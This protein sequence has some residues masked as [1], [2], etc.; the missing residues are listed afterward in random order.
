MRSEKII[1]A[2]GGI[3]GI[4][5]AIELLKAGFEVEL[6]ERFD[7]KNFGGLAK[8]SFG[9][10][11]FV[12][13]PTQRRLGIKDSFEL[14]RGDWWSV[15]GFENSDYWPKKW[16]EHYISHATP[17]VYK[18]LR[19]FGIGFFPVV[20]WVERG[21]LKRGNSVPRFHMVWGTGH[22]L[23]RV[24][25][26]QLRSDK[27]RLHFNHKVEN[28]LFDGSGV[29]GIT[30][31]NEITGKEIK[32]EGRAVIVATGGM[33]G[34]IEKVKKHWYRPWGT[35]PEVLLNGL[36]PYI[37]G[38]L[39][40]VVKKLNGKIT[41]LDLHWHYA[42][43]VH[44]PR[45]GF[46]GEGISLVPPKSALW[47]NYKGERIGPHPLITAYDTRFLVEG[48]CR[49]AKKYSWLVLNRKIALK[50]LAVSG[51]EFNDA[52]RNKSI[53][54]FLKTILTGNK[55]L[56]NDL[57]ENCQDFVTAGSVDELVVKMNALNGDDAVDAAVLKKAIADY[58]AAIDRGLR[59]GR[60]DDEQLQKIAEARKYRG[61][62][63][64]TCKFQKINDPAA[65]PLIAIRE[66][67]IS[68]KTLGGIQTDLSGRVLSETGDPVPGL[69]AVGEASGFGGGGS[70]GKG[71]LEGTFLGTCILTARA[72]AWHLSDKNIFES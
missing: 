36:H 50:E 35:P 19:G 70:H 23:T 55:K 26:K 51:A 41:H 28:L 13:T 39:T 43:G 1:I 11:F 71:A 31:K 14:A 45:P 10:M 5:A 20:H 33:G 42:A 63:V 57:T 27:L 40:D 47:V 49:Q 18:W 54:A 34:N 8:K 69:Y 37:D 30:A 44:H 53:V 3:S 21:Y 56:V 62:K 16:A 29:Y 6:F 24:L 9:G 72:A 66:F 67:I 38:H 12:D 46:E 61:D 52:I 68:R 32:A 22:E 25:I 65:Y 15:A 4:T 17:L 64:R 7:E 48:V 59:L 60:F 58:D 2:G